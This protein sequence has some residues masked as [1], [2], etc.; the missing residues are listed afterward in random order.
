MK[1]LITI[2]VSAALTLGIALPALA[3]VPQTQDAA[4]ASTTTGANVTATQTASPSM[5]TPSSTKFSKTKKYRVHKT[6]QG[7]VLI[8]NADSFTFTS[9]AKEYTAQLSASTK[10]VNRVRK[11]ITLTDISVGD[12]VRVYGS[13]SS[14]TVM[15]QIVRDTTRPAKVKKTTAAST[16]RLH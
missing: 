14:L 16:S 1:K 15:A 9:G 5:T 4:S 11:A 6:L 7:K 2:G 13:V 8:V 10:V 3:F 12:T